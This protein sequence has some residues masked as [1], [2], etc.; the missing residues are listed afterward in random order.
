MF[1][2]NEIPEQLPTSGLHPSGAAIEFL[3][4]CG[5]VQPVHVCKTGSIES[6]DPCVSVSTGR[7]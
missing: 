3:H 1:D 4:G 5:R 6:N 2:S 7:L